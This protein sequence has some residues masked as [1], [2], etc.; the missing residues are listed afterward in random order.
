MR[1]LFPLCRSLTGP[2]VR[3]TLRVLGEELPL[4]TTEVASGTPMLDW[5]APLE[6]S[7]VDAY[8][9]DRSGRRLVDFRESNLHVVSYSAPVRGT[10]RFEEIRDRLFTLPD[11]PELIPYR[12]SYWNETWGFCLAHERLEELERAGELVVVIES[13]LAPGHMVYGEV[14]TPGQTPDEVLLSTHVCHPSLAN[15]NLSGVALLATIARRLMHTRPRLT[16]RFLFSPGTVGPIAW[17]ARNGSALERIRH[18]LVVVSVGD[19]GP[20][21][22]K[23][24]RRGDAAVA[25]AADHVLSG[26]EGGSLRDFEPWGCDERQ[27]CSPGFDLP[28]GCLMRTPPGEYPENHTSADDLAFV[29][30]EALGDAG[31]ACLEILAVLEEDRTLVNTSP[32]GEPQLGRRGLFRTSG[33]AGSGQAGLPDERA[34]LWVLNQADGGN[35]LLDIAE[36]SGI[37]FDVVLEAARALEHAGLVEESPGASPASG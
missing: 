18:G 14:V 10:F 26:S 11:R 33:G 15:D 23:R 21:T 13:R 2:G 37:P 27:F 19:P 1:T 24:S 29:T 5:T 9:A 25:R 12:T 36:R 28:V 6:W 20:L 31:R 16:H 4:E 22:Y 35:S 7:I 3:E 30:S 34:L 8:I 32:Y 17:L